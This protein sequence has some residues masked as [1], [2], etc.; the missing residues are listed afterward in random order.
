[1]IAVLKVFGIFL[2]AE[3]DS[4]LR[5]EHLFVNLFSAIQILRDHSITIVV[6]LTIILASLVDFVQDIVEQLHS[7]REA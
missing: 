4:L 1:M 6:H 2:H 7:L 5:L 3:C